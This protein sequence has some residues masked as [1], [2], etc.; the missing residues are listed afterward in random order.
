[1]NPYVSL[2][3]EDHSNEA[4]EHKSPWQQRK[5]CKCTTYTFAKL[6][7]IHMRQFCHLAHVR[8][9]LHSHLVSTR[10]NIATSCPHKIM[11]LS[12]IN[13]RWLW[14]DVS[15]AKGDFCAVEGTTW[16]TMW[17]GHK[18][19]MATWGEIYKVTSCPCETTLPPHPREVRFT[20]SPHVDARWMVMQGTSHLLIFFTAW[21]L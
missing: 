16:H 14:I 13:T 2:H 1:M 9:D 18:V 10:D 7:H 5:P 8:W 11:M 6:P 3:K 4:S 12:H 19:R 20:K 15:L 21:Y 17:G